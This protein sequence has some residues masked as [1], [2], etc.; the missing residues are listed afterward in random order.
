MSAQRRKGT[1]W[2]LAIVDYLRSV[3]FVHAERRAASGAKDRGDVAG[4]PGTVIEAKTG[5]RLELSAWL[6]EAEAERI[7]D[8]AEYGVVWIKRRGRASPR[9][10]YVVMTG[11]TYAAMLADL[12]GIQNERHGVA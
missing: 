1:A 5:A 4:I 6:A 12:Y 7:N 11:E 8:G 10:G 2:E 9:H 3:G